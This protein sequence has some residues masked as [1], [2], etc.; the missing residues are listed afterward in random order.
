MADISSIKLFHS[1]MA[2]VMEAIPQVLEM[3][4]QKA[5]MER[6][7]A[8]YRQDLEKAKA[9]V[10][11]AYDEADRRITES[12]GALSELADKRE[13]LNAEIGRLDSK[14]MTSKEAIED[15]INAAKYAADGA[16]IEHNAR[17]AEAERISKERIAAAEQAATERAAEL[18]KS[19]ADLEAREAKAQKAL[20]ALRS[21][22]G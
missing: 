21:K 4:E 15:A 11:A 18:E 2:P 1:M 22:L 5:D 17:A 14:L 16:V 3:L 7:M 19:I 12:N 6:S 9:E 10:Q 20:E 8:I 13:A